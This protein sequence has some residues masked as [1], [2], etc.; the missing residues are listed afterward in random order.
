MDLDESNLKNWERY[1]PEKIG[2][3]SKLPSETVRYFQERFELKKKPLV[4][5][6][7]PHILYRG[8]LDT[9]KLEVIEV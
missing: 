9:R 3:Y 4:W 5:V 7:V 1:E 2:S 6:Y 8:T